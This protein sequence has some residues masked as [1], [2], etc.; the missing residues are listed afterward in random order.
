MLAVAALD[1]LREA[2]MRRGG[3]KVISQKRAQVALTQLL[4][5]CRPERLAEFTG[6]GLAAS[7]NVPVAVAEDLLAKARQG[8]LV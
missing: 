4:T 2:L 3:T 8:W 6:A 1:Q 5:G 7:Y